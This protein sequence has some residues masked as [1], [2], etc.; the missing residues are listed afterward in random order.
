MET[1]MTDTDRQTRVDAA[2]VAA[3]IE[4]TCA[5]LALSEEPSNFA[6]AL[7]AGGTPGRQTS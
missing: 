4:R 6:A 7:E 2:D 5:D 3:L 1:S